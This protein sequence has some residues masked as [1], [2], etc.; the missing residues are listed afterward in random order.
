MN[1]SLDKTNTDSAAVASRLSHK[2]SG[3]DASLACPIAKAEK[4]AAAAADNWNVFDNGYEEKQAAAER[5]AYSAYKRANKK[6]GGTSSALMDIKPR[7]NKTDM[8]KLEESVRS[9]QMD[10]LTWG[11]STVV[12]VGYGI[13]KLQIT[14]MFMDDVVSVETLIDEVL[15][16]ALSND[17]VQSCD[18]V[19]F[20]KI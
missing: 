7:D 3:G 11:A 10:G 2:V 19:A 17:Y 18:I 8:N 14:L 15:C 16:H 1:L 12:P 9:I 5:A 13:K 4:G 20:N 6:E